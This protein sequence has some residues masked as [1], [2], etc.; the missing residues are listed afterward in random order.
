MHIKT[1]CYISQSMKQ[2]I[3]EFWRMAGVLLRHDKTSQLWKYELTTLYDL[4]HSMNPT[5]TKCWVQFTCYDDAIQ[6]CLDVD[7]AD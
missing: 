4:Y 5:Y 3:K 1:S 7:L 2:K 6:L